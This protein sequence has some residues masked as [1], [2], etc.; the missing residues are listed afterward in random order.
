MLVLIAEEE[1][2]DR[3]IS[4][5]KFSVARTSFI[6]LEISL[7]AVMTHTCP[8]VFFYNKAGKASILSKG[9]ILRIARLGKLGLEMV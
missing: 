9:D 3:D 1:K 4:N 8:D 7:L 2:S 5:D 6:E